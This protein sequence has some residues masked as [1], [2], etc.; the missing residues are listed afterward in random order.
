MLLSRH[1]FQQT[2]YY[3]FHTEI[4]P[5]YGDLDPQV[6]IN[7]VA[8]A[9]LYEEGRARFLRWLSEQALRPLDPPKRMIASVKIDYLAQIYYPSNLSIAAG[10][11]AVGRSSYRIAQAIFQ[12]G[13]CVGLCET[14]VVHSDG[15]R[16]RE[17][18]SVW[19][20][21][22]ERGAIQATARAA[23]IKAGE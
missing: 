3:P 22:L 14:V 17:I 9:S 5:R 6:H 16:S 19:R 13:R 1:L 10:I 20:K 18:S 12:D 11:F 23:E 21:T 4:S 2:G 15:Q 8:V 7:N